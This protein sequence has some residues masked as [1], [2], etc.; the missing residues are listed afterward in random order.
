M[1]S[2]ALSSSS[3]SDGKDGIDVDKGAG[4]GAEAKIGVGAVFAKDE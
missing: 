4:G 3:I 2:I 1:D